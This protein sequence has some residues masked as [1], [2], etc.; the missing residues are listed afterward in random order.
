[1]ET[2]DILVIGAGLIGCS[3]ARELARANQQVTVVERATVGAGASSAAAGLLSPS[4]STVSAG[5][6]FELCRQ[7]AHLYESWIGELR[8]EGAGEVGFHRPGLLEVWTDPQEAERRNPAGPFEILSAAD[9]RR[10]EPALGPHVQGGAFD[11][12]AAHVDS[13][14]LTRAVARLAAAAGVE[15][16]EHESVLRVVREGDRLTAVHTTTTCYWPGLVVLTAGAWSGGLAEAFGLDLPTQPIKGQLLEANG[17]ASPIHTPVHMGNVLLLPRP[18]GRLLLGVTVEEDGFDDRVTLEGMRSILAGVCALAPAVGALSLT[19][20]W[21]GL[22][23]ATPDGW[24]YLGPVPPVRNLWVSTGHFRKGILLA[25]LCARLMARSILA[26]H[27]DDDLVPFKPT[28][29]LTA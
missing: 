28:R 17:R 3:L 13:A 24:P 10:R 6:L 29:R 14:Q 1:M 2:P 11:P 15:L 21:A 12:D 26:D 16:R 7:S 5:P 4:V 18:E 22:R 19:R 25:P 8:Q 23:P 27:L 9:L 20:A